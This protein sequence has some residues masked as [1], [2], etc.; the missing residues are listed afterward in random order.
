MIYLRGV[1]MGLK[2]VELN[3][4]RLEMFILSFGICWKYF[5][6]IAASKAALF[7]CKNFLKLVVSKV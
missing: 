4:V 5:Y 7:A 1:L 3:N 2:A 6:S